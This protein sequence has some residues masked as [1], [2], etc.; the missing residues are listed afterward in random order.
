MTSALPRTILVTG[1]AGFIGSALSK[2]LLSEGCRVIGIDDFNSYYPVELKEARV[3]DIGPN[4]AFTLVRGDISDKALLEK[5]FSDYEPEA[6]VNLA[7]QA[8]VRYSIEN[9]DA[10]TRS[11]LVGFANLLEC[12][13]HHKVGHFVFASSSSVYGKNKKVPFSEDD[14]VDFPVSYY[15]ATKKANE[16]MAASY[17][18][19][20]KLPLTGLRFFTVYGPWGRPDM[21]PW[22]FTDAIL[23]GR[24]IKV[25]NNGD[26]MRDFTFIDDIVEGVVRVIGRVP[27]GDF[28]YEIFN[29][30]NHSPVRLMDF[31]H[32]IV[33][34]NRIRKDFIAEEI[35]K[36]NP[37]R[38]GV[39]RLIMKSGSDNFRASS[40]QGIMRRLKE[41]GIAL[42]VYEPTLDADTFLDTPVEH[43]LAAFKSHCDLIITNRNSPDLADVKDK[44]FTRDLF[45]NN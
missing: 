25:F 3:A 16:L 6:V 43:D 13:R 35:A 27:Q 19:L 33:D 29:I 4:P 41:K 12:C 10:Y 11:N 2:R 18:N 21:A 38:V 40:I 1:A 32:E 17:A 42:E 20:Y 26:M 7:A 15:A 44:V 24:P 31:I 14:R 22:L 28:P 8:G 9:P 37:K 34:S 39:Y 30:G 36:K 5:V 45:G 23:A